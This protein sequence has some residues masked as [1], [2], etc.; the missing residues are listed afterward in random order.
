MNLYIITMEVFMEIFNEE[1]ISS[2]K[3]KFPS[4]VREA[5]RGYEVITSNFK[6]AKEG[7]VSIISTSL[8]EENLDQGY[9]FH[10]VIEEDEEGRGFTISLEELLIHGA[11]PTLFGVLQD[12]AGNLMDYTSDYIKRI[13]FFRQ[14]ENRK[15]LSLPAQDCK[16]P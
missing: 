9:K 16:M 1:S 4:L 2:A 13:V 14:I 12:L 10:P 6:S 8:Y 5:A 3:Q 15:G 7:K 11:G